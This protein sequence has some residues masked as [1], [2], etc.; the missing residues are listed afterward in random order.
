MKTVVIDGVEHEQISWEAAFAEHHDSIIHLRPLPKP[1]KT[2][3]QV[4]ADAMDLSEEFFRKQHVV[5]AAVYD[6]IERRL[7]ALEGK[8]K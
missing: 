5:T 6:E 1:Q 3:V 7:Q 8:G 4:C 2:L